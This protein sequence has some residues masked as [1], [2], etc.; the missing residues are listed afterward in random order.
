[1]NVIKCE[2]CTNVLAHY[3]MQMQKFLH[4]IC[5]QCGKDGDWEGLNDDQRQRC[6]EIYRWANMT[7]E[8]RIAYDRNRG[9]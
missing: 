7:N 3:D 2:Q 1:M 4:G 6:A 5:L 9:N 8:Q